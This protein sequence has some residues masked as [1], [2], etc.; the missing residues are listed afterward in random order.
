MTQNQLFSWRG[1]GGV[2]LAAVIIFLIGAFSA[3]Y[4][5]QYPLPMTAQEKLTAI[6]NDRLG[7]TFQAVSFPVVFLAT[8]IVFG[9]FTQRLPASTARWLALGATICM[10]AGFLLWLPIAINRLQLAAQA[11]DLLRNL[12]PNAPPSLL[13]ANAWSFWPHTVAV[14]AAVGLMGGALALGGVLPTL[15]WVV[16]GLAVIGGAAGILAMRDWPPFFSYVFLL[17]MAIGLVRR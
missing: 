4:F 9:L 7:W 14:L 1:L 6:A 3:A 17:V 12:D 11:A 13:T 5:R 16:T 2:L 10:A 8:T 15:G